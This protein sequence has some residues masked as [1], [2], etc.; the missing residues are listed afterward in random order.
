MTWTRF[1]DASSG[2]YQKLRWKVIYIEAPE[3]EA[4]LIFYNKFRRNPD[5]VTCT[6][7]GEDYSVIEDQT[8]WESVDFDLQVRKKCGVEVTLHQ[9]LC[10]PDV[11]VIHAAEIKPEWRQGKIPAEGFVWAGEGFV[12]A[13]GEE[14]WW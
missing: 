7:C 4:K 10:L 3:E 2:G 1:Y 14:D 13:G 12:W 11:L 8:L 6:C 5:R 9:F